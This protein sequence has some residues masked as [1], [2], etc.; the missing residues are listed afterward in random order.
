MYHYIYRWAYPIA[1]CQALMKEIANCFF[2]L[3]FFFIFY[4]CN[5][6]SINFLYLHMYILRMPSLKFALFFI[7][8][9]YI[10]REETF[11]LSQTRSSKLE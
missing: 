4:F 3:Q 6:V 10:Y 7:K 1:K 2:F 5:S 11:E 9:F 8:K